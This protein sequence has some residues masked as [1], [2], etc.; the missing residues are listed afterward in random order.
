MT[1][2]SQSQAFD[3]MFD[4]MRRQA[5]NEASV[6]YAH[7]LH[8]MEQKFLRRDYPNLKARVQEHVNS[9]EQIPEELMRDYINATIL[10]GNLADLVQG[11]KPKKE[12]QTEIEKL[13]T[14]EVVEQFKIG[15]EKLAKTGL[16]PALALD[17][18]GVLGNYG[19]IDSILTPV[20]MVGG[21]AGYFGG[22]NHYVEGPIFAGAVYLGAKIAEAT[23]D[24]LKDGKLKKAE[25][26]S[27]PLIK[28][29]KQN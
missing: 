5:E 8:E 12:K 27:G 7:S 14:P 26:L 2:T 3:T 24:V 9:A 16:I 15:A 28:K 6:R 25:N 18:A 4:Y 20:A 23:L 1:S 10:T 29:T 11:F 21:M 22:R 13:F 17:A 19:T